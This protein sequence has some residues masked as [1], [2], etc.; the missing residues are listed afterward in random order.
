VDWLKVEALVQD[1]VPPKKKKNVS[2]RPWMLFLE[3]NIRN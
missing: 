3:T 2:E 1:P